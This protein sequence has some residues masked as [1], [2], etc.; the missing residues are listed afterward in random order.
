[1][2]ALKHFFLICRHRHHVIANGR[3]CGIFW[4]CLRHDLSKF[5]PTEFFR[6]AKFYDG[7]HSPVLEERKENDYFSLICQHHTKHNKHHWE[8][9]VDFFKGH[10][11]MLT[12]PWVYATEYVCDVLSASYCY[13]P[14]SF[15]GEKARDYFDERKDHYFMTTITKEYI[16]WCLDRFATMGYRGLKKKDTKAKYQELLGKYPRVEWASSDRAQGNLPHDAH[17]SI[18]PRE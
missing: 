2:K 8:Y 16:H 11:I 17:E 13:D 14:K 3:R 6:S 5:G 10:I 18:M 12:M 1:M 15:S 7:S 4:H 9:W